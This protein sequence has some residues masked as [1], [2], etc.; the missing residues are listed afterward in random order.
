[1]ALALE[2]VTFFVGHDIFLQ[3]EATGFVRKSVLDLRNTSS[4][5]TTAEE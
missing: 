1:M 2:L 5:S 3:Q 4:I